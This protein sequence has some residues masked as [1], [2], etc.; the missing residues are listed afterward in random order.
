MFISLLIDEYPLKQINNNKIHNLYDLKYM[1]LAK[2]LLPNGQQ[3]IGIAPGAG[4]KQKIWP[5]ENFIEIK[6]SITVGQSWKNDIRIILFIV[7][8][9]GFLLNTLLVEKIKKTIKNNVSPRHV[10]SKIIPVSDIPKT[11]NGKLVELTVK[12]IIEG[13]AIKNLETLANPDSLEQFK[14]IKEL[15]E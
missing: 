7:L 9:D 1:N 4:D 10:P 6:E 12:K 11:K 2:K 14:N 13:E 5:V 8:N 15:Y 3:Y